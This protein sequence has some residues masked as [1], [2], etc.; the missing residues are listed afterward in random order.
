MKLWRFSDPSDY[1][2]ARAGRYGGTWQEGEPWRRAKPLS[3]T[4]LPDSDLVG[5]FTWPGLDTDIVI[6]NRVGKAL[7][8]AAVTGFELAPVEM[9]ENS[10]VS[11]RMSKKPRVRL[12]YMGAQLWDLWVTAWAPLDR[13]RSTLKVVG[14]QPDGSE[15]CEVSG[16]ER[17]EALWDQQRME[18]VKVRHPLVKGQGLFV[19]PETGIFRIAEVPG[20]IFC[21]DEVKRLIENHD[22]TNVSFLEMG[23]VQRPS[24]SAT[25]RCIG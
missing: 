10:E 19:R 6:T 22:F 8:E 12:P 2:Y 9:V 15:R 7:Q 13:E 25:G 17:C 11:K 21:T 20:W 3:I 5:D 18:L 24:A 16:V 14:K 4:W 1:R 23:Q